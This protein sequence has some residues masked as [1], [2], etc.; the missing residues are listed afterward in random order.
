MPVE[1]PFLIIV[2]QAL[3]SLHYVQHVVGQMLAFGD[4]V[5]IE[6]TKLITIEARIHIV[7]VLVAKLLAEVVDLVLDVDLGLY[8]DLR[9][10]FID[11]FHHFGQRAFHK[12][13]HRLHVLSLLGSECILAMHAMTIERASQVIY[14]V[15]D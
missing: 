12:F 14:R 9:F 11:V 15:A 6:H 4:E 13:Q 10:R 2:V 3:S 7:H 5:H 1:L 8:A